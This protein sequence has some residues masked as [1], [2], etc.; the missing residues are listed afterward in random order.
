MEGANTGPG[1]MDGAAGA[2]ATE[3]EPLQPNWWQTFDFSEG[4]SFEVQAEGDWWQVNARRWQ[5]TEVLVRYVGGDPADDFWVRIDD[6]SVRPP[7]APV[8][9]AHGRVG[10]LVMVMFLEGPQRVPAWYKGEISKFS[11]MTP[12]PAEGAPADAPLKPKQ[13]MWTID[14]E[15][16]GESSPYV[17]PDNEVRLHIPQADVIDA[18]VEMKRAANE[19]FED[20]ANRRELHRAL[21]ASLTQTVKS[22]YS[23]CEAKMKARFKELEAYLPHKRNEIQCLTPSETMATREF[24]TLLRDKVLQGDVLQAREWNLL[25]KL[26]C[27]PP[28]PRGP[29]QAKPSQSTAVAGGSSATKISIVHKDPDLKVRI[30]L[31]GAGGDAGTYMSRG[32]LVEVELGEE[33]GVMVPGGNVWELG[34]VVSVSPD[35]KDVGVSVCDVVIDVAGSKVRPVGGGGGDVP[36]MLRGQNVRGWVRAYK[37]GKYQVSPK[38]SHRSK[39]P[40]LRTLILACLSDRRKHR[41]TDGWMVIHGCIHA[42]ICEL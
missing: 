17:L 32:A 29:D 21:I 31:A 6:P 16:D 39:I 15:D 11:F 30:S 3:K 8:G 23:E 4:A 20:Y 35:G 22:V 41:L 42:W 9:N 28:R 5:G 37:D 19:A 18:L 7:Q 36:V 40:A 10:N 26:I 13:W 12:P 14:F 25:S 34:R 24:M 27:P 33:H 2:P 38:R 1:G